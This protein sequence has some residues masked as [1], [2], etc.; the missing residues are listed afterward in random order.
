MIGI[1]L[2][3]GD[4]ATGATYTTLIA[5]GRVPL[6]QRSSVL[7]KLMRFRIAKYVLLYTGYA[8]HKLSNKL[9]LAFWSVW[10]SHFRVHGYVFSFLPNVKS[11]DAGATEGRLK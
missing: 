6:E 11:A 5:T 1:D 9:T 4:P 2:T 3:H 7:D 8:C 10:E